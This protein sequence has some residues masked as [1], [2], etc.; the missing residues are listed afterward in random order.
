MGISDASYSHSPDSAVYGTDQGACH[1]PAV[2]AITSSLLFHIH[3]ENAHG[4]QVYS[5][6]L[7]WKFMMNGFVDNTGNLTSTFE[8]VHILHALAT[9]DTQLWA[10]L[11]FSSGGLLKLAKCFLY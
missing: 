7:N 1:S 3:K 6:N 8:S 10:D 2:W 4:A 11:L 9:C 5:A